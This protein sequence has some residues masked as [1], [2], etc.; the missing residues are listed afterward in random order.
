MAFVDF[1][2]RPLAEVAP[3]GR[4][5]DP[6]DRH[7]SWF[8]L[9]DGWYTIDAKDG[10]LFQY[11][12][13]MM[14]HLNP[15]FDSRAAY[16]DWT[17]YQVVRLYEDLLEMMPD[18]LSEVPDDVHALVSTVEARREWRRTV[19]WV[20]DSTDDSQLDTL[21]AATEWARLRKLDSLYL[22]DGPRIWL[23]RNQARV[24]VQ[25]DNANLKT[26]GLPRWTA[27]QG[28]ASLAVEEFVE[29]IG[30]FHRRLISAM[31]ERVNTIATKNPLA[32]VAIDVP[33][34]I[35]EQSERERSLELASSV[36]ATPIDWGD[37]IAA[38]RTLRKPQ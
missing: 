20:Y 4:P 11:T 27:T 26:D 22:I 25:W 9:T 7:L 8:G 13:E 32:G 2:L 12:Q 38:T 29:E 28:T 16:C 30:S 31:A 3:W 10:R 37:V 35:E 24:Y 6:T 36:A 15:K 19:D 1:A 5:D 34:L 21:E 33:R 23:W 17:D 18:V 14:R